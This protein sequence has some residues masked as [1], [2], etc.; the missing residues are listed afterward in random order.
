MAMMD[1]GALLRIDGVFVNKD[2]ALC[3]D[4]PDFVC[5]SAEYNDEQFSS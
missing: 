4:V 2:K 5:E 1:Y 3:I